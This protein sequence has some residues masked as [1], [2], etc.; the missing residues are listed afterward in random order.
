MPIVRIIEGPVGA[1]KSTFSGSLATRTGGVHIALD[2]WFAKLFSP[3][4]PAGDL[5][6][7]YLARK[8]RL[9]RL[10]WTHSKAVLA[11]GS[12]VI[13]ELGL[14][15][16][17]PRID[18]CR[19]VIGEGF[20]LVMYELDAPREVRRARVQHRNSNQGPTFSMVVPDHVFE[21]ASNMWEPSDE[22]ER[23]EYKIEYVRSDFSEEVMANHS[24]NEHA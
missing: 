2:E 1:G 15:Q 18:F 24:F 4:R 7:W 8:E 3:D 13:L 17:Q 20:G 10:I 21:M 22:L 19:Q 9:L 6:S 12:D 11:S 16:Q 14:I 5:I 23:D